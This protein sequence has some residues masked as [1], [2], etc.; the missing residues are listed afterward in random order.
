[1]KIIRLSISA[2]L[3]VLL[4]VGLAGGAHARGGLYF[5]FDLGGAKVYGDTNINLDV[6]V[7][8]T[9]CKTIGYEN[10]RSDIG[11]GFATGIR[12]GYNVMGFGGIEAVVT[13][14]GNKKSAGNTWEGAG[15]VA[16]VAR[17]WPIQFFTLSKKPAFQSLK[18][19]PYDANLY[20]GY[21]IFAITGYHVD[22]STGRGWEGTSLQWGAAFD[23]FVAKTVSVGVDF[24]F[25]K[26][27]YDNFILKWDPRCAKVLNSHD[28]VLT[29]A[30]MATIT[31]H[32][33]DPHE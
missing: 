5:G 1:M 29:F 21:G 15:D 27:M 18:T 10:I 17:V 16:A 26:S 12:F 22:S 24:K 4:C 7:A 8:E 33:L 23:Y 25:V 30:P 28:S 32:L 20:F 14:H 13:A 11:S 6:N 19:R 3:T 31:F 9:N 2:L